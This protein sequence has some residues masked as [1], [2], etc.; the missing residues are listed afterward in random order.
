M[1]RLISWFVL[2]VKLKLNAAHAS[3]DHLD[4]MDHQVYREETV[5][6]V[7][8]LERP[9][10]QVQML[11]SMIG[12]FQYLHNVHAKL[13]LDLLDRLDHLDLMDNLEALDQMVMMEHQVPRD[14]QDRQ[15]RLVK[16]DNPDNVDHQV[17]LDNSFR[18][19]DHHQDLLDNQDDQVH[20]DNL[21]GLDHQAEMVRMEHPVAQESQDHVVHQVQLDN[22][23]HQVSKVNQV[24]QEAVIIVHQHVLLPVIKH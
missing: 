21:A 2:L 14:H 10:H 8:D 9:D 5:L 7:K 22:R 20:Q 6:Q 15:V 12:C 11:I 13:H 4:Q 17:N 23:D 3:K 24:H 18:A 1:N 16:M 19:N